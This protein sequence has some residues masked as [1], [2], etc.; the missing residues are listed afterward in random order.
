MLFLDF[1]KYNTKK[2]YK[3]YKILF[4]LMVSKKV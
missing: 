3:K 1:R 4:Y 2:K